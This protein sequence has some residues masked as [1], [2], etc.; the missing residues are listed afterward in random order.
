L[1]KQTDCFQVEDLSFCYRSAAAPALAGVTMRI[2]RGVTT[3]VVGLSGSGK[4]TLLSALGLLSGARA[5]S[6]GKIVFKSM[7]EEVDYGVAND[8]TLNQLRMHQ[9]GF[10]LQNAFLLPHFSCLENVA[11][12]LTIQGVR[13]EERRKKAMSLLASDKEYASDLSH[14]AQKPARQTSGGERQRLALYRALIHEPQVIFADEPLN[15]LDFMNSRFVADRLMQWKNDPRHGDARSLII[16][17]HNLD[18]IFEHVDDFFVMSHGRLLRQK[19][20]SQDE[21]PD[22]VDGLRR[23]M[24]EGTSVG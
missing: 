13:V 5:I 14:L 23:L 11:F 15:N 1:N 2:R 16:V 19:P 6:G 21:L 17:S 10:V 12:P 24:R 8:R 4:T 22:G 7:H 9:F 18:T 20:F 3:A